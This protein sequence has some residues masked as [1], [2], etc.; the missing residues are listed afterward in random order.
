MEVG[1]FVLILVGSIFKPLFYL[2][3]EDEEL[4]QIES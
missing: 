4:Y 3:P 2:F 1:K